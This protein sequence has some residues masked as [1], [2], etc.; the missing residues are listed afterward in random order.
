MFIFTSI[1]TFFFF[2]LKKNFLSPQVSIWVGNM[3]YESFVPLFF[4]LRR[5]S[6]LVNYDG[7]KLEKFKMNK[8]AV[9]L[10]L[11]SEFYKSRVKM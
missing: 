3:L 7:A 8:K 5:K 11:A 1:L 10:Y 6:K 9:S 2:F 4:G